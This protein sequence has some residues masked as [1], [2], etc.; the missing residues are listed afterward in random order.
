MTEINF[1]GDEDWTR[2]R[3]DR[4]GEA[5][6]MMLFA[7]PFFVLAIAAFIMRMQ[8]LCIVAVVLCGAVMIF[9]YDLRVSPLV[10]YV[11]YLREL[12]Q[13]LT[14]QTAATLVSIGEDDVFQ[15]HVNVREVIVNVFEDMHPDGERR[16]WLDS[17]KKL[18]E[19]WKGRDVAVTSQGVYITGMR[20]MGV[21]Q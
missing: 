20:L 5:K 17:S 16:F 6:K 4:N 12:R 15:E 10:W 19:E 7:L 14:H 11:R 18:P 13:G 2:A 1:Y 8:M 21:G 3:T 9:Y